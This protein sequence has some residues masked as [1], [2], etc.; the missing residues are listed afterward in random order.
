MKKIIFLITLF[1][2]T[3]YTAA[4]TPLTS[5]RTLIKQDTAS[6]KIDTTLITGFKYFKFTFAPDSNME[7]T[8]QGFNLVDSNGTSLDSGM[9]KA[10][11][12]FTSPDWIDGK[13]FSKFMCRKQSTATGEAYYRLWVWGRKE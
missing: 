7:Y 4:Q 8:F 10:G 9:V 6:R 1:V 2:I 11:E 12:S 3:G 5:N 13:T